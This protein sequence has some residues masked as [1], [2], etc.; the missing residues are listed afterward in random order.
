M[1][2]TVSFHF[3]CFFQI[4]LLTIFLIFFGVPY[5]Q[6]YLEHNV[7]VVNHRRQTGGV[8]APAITIIA[9]NP[10]TNQGWKDEGKL[11]DMSEGIIMG[12]CM[13]SISVEKCIREQTYN[14]SD[15]VNTIT[16]GYNK[17]MTIMETIDWTEDFTSQKQG[18]YF[19][20]RDV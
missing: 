7:M 4:F 9:R 8:E 19:T 14:K 20:I 5:A 12:H 17:Q 18:R 15:V 3:R 10:H 16:K 6:K 1:Y 2:R 13:E 11:M